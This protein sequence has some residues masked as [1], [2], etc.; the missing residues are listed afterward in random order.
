MSSL[1]PQYTQRQGMVKKYFNF[2]QSLMLLKIVNFHVVLLC[3][4][5]LRTY[6]HAYIQILLHIPRVQ[7]S[8]VSVCMSA[9]PPMA[10]LP[11]SS[12]AI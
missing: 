8:G 1:Q 11:N 2:I 7:Q 5:A 12:H 3:L 4:P 6:M 9:Y 10:Q